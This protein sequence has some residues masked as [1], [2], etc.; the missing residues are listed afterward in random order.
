[1]A[2][3]AASIRLS[4]RTDAKGALAFVLLLFMPACHAA[5]RP[6][7]VPALS[8]AGGATQLQRDIETILTAPTLTRS[9]WGVLVKC[10]KNND[11]LYSLNAG[12]LLMPG[13]T[14]KIVTLA[15]AAERLGWDYVYD[16]RLVA[17][18]SI[19]AGVLNGAKDHVGSL[20]RQPALEVL[21][22]ALVGAVLAPHRV[23]EGE[24]GER[25]RALQQLSDAPSLAQLQRQRLCTESP[26]Q[27][28][29]GKSPDVD[30]G[31]HG[32]RLPPPSGAGKKEV[33]C[34]G[35][36]HILGKSG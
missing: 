20:G 27:L 16:T 31:F 12:K 18:G 19:D 26:L 30:H 8:V 4:S 21:A 15:A 33:G 14:I 28:G 35:K 34:A 11:T 24:L 32:C 36:G 22:A 2:V 13:S 7:V 3:R 1:M 9:Y 25:G 17:A 29:V 5:P 6:A 10:A 23:E